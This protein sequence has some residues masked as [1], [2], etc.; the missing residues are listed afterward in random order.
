[1]IIDAHQHFLEYTAHPDHYVWM[2]SAYSQLRRNYLPEHLLPLLVENGIDGTVA[3]QARELREETLFLLAISDRCS[4][5]KG[6]VGW[7]DLCAATLDS[8]LEHCTE[9]PKLSGLRMLIHDQLD[10]DF[11]D[12]PAHLR[13]VSR[14]SNYNLT[15]DLL[16]KPIHLPAATRLVDHYPNQMFVVDHIAKPDILR[17]E[18]EPWRSGIADIGRRPNVFCK[19]SSMITQAHWQTW[20][21][22]QIEPYL[23]WTLECFGAQRLMIGSDWP[24]S[25]CATDYKTT[26]NLV[27][28]WAARLSPTEQL[29]VLGNSCSRFYHLGESLPCPE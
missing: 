2:N 8:D 4:F 13:G 24:V 18:I 12:S 23:D 9:H 22:E 3:V 14:L 20:L 29:A 26:M 28:Q 5:V 19:L 1:M 11:A 10:V 27:V 6:V 17:G 25:T 7:L 21:P 16:L 15:Y